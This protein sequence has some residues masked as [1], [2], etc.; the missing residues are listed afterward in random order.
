MVDL[1]PPDALLIGQRRL[2]RAVGWVRVAAATVLIVGSLITAIDAVSVLLGTALI[3]NTVVAAVRP[4]AA[5]GRQRVRQV[6]AAADIGVV[7]LA[8]LVFSLDPLSALPAVGALVI[9]TSSLRA[10][11]S[12]ALSYAAALS[13]AELAST[14]FGARVVG[15]PLDPYR[16]VA[17]LAVYQLTVP[18]VR[19]VDGEFRVLGTQ[20]EYRALYDTLTGL[21]G[22]ELLLDATERTIAAAQRHASKLAILVIELR[23]FAAVNTAFGYETGDLLLQQVAPR[24]LD[25]LPEARMVGRLGG[26]KFAAL[27]PEAPDAARAVVAAQRVL[28]ALQRPVTVAQHALDIEASIGIALH[29]Q[30]GTRADVLLRH[31]EHAAL[32][33]RGSGDGYAFASETEP[34]DAGRLELAAELRAAI[35][36]DEL[37]LH[38]QPMVSMKTARVVGAEALVRWS[39]P[40]RGLLAPD[41]FIHVAEGTTLIKPLTHWV[42]NTALR[43]CRAWREAG[44]DLGVA[45]NVSMGNLMDPQLPATL[46]G[47]L[48]ASGA[49]ASWVAL[50]IT[51]SV[52]MARP[53]RAMEILS[54]LR[55]MGVRLV[56]DDFGTGYSS[57]AYLHR[58]AVDEVKIDKSFV[59]GMGTDVSSVA[60]VRA[61]IELGRTLDFETCAEGVEDRATWEVLASIGCDEAQGYYVATPMTKTELDR[62]LKDSPWMTQGPVG[63]TGVT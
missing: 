32:A 5:A 43:D 29:P 34:G 12:H 6:S 16:L 19:W 31:G 36:R 3:A 30:N 56:I 45:V 54:Q 23:N 37:L 46:R 20:L 35:D 40:R 38:Y 50:E 42:L 21:P 61:A 17:D 55:R 13:I 52:L 1:K 8:M 41:A 18:L 51:E 58:L 9:V 47:L 4:R 60:I 2:E 53:E 62:W 27:L 25:S 33:A 22:L 63:D 14:L 26:A 59:L 24:L 15:A 49:E 44:H 39:H 48:D 7:C 57:L 28:R 11:A 10:G